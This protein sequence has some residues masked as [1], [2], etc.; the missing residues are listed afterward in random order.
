MQQI[1]NRLEMKHVSKSFG[2]VR[3]LEDVSIDIRRG[4]IH[5]LVGENGAGKSTL[6]KV[7]SGAYQRDDGEIYVDGQLTNIQSPR[8]AKN[9]G[10]SVIYQEFMLAPDLTV[11][12]NIYM[13]QLTAGK[14][15][16]NWRELDRKARDQLSQLGFEDISPRAKVRDLSVAYQQVV[17]ICKNLAKDIRILVLDEPT[18]VLTFAEIERLFKILKQ[19]KEQGVS[20][21]YISHRLD[22]IFQLSQRI[23]VL[24]D[25]QIVG[26][27]MTDEID[28]N[29]LVSMM[30]GRTMSQMFPERHAV[31][32]EDVLRVESI[33]AGEMVRNISFHVRAGEVLGFSGLV[34]SGRTETMRAIF[35][36]D[37]LESGRI[38]YLG[39]EVRFKNPGDAIK[40]GLGMVPENRKEQGLLLQ[41]SIRI[42]ATMAVLKRKVSRCG[43][44][45]HKAEKKY[46][47][48][49]LKDIATKYGSLED[50]VDS[51]S[52]GNQ[53][54]VS[55]AKWIAADCKCIIF[56]EPTRG[57]DV[58]AKVE[59]Y[60]IIN[61]LAEE[62][63][64]IVIISSEMPEIIG[65]CDRVMVMRMG[66]VTAELSQDEITEN[67]MIKAAMGV[68]QV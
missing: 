20:I 65:M 28:K 19:L 26:T 1:Q 16:I 3:A 45:N 37:P 53:Q 61:K 12:E 56:D 68:E 5:A 17:E 27:V 35:G 39:E 40:H 63:V 49:L 42:N 67:N 13:D 33:C 48:K 2:G 11:A 57:V 31:I 64:A 58:G 43:V 8:D 24:R 38:V 6:M 22:E 15:I 9:L 30:V 4:E 36:A 29:G 18:A 21:I 32:G 52:G 34:G 10:I 14:G 55:L 54:K 47:A 66:E 7:L 62:G 46:S 44:I 51:L 59:I 50:H 41:L 23:T 25:G 60:N